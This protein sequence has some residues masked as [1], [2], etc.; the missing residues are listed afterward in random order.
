M[1]IVTSYPA[2]FITFVHSLLVM[3]TIIYV[4]VIALF[5]GLVT[6]DFAGVIFTPIVAGVIFLA[7][8]LVE[9]VVVKH[10]PLAFPAMDMA[11][12]KLAVAVYITFLVLDL[13]VF[14]VKKLV[15]KITG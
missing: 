3:P 13:V 2:Y 7:V 10:A 6:K 11:F 9:P 12:A 15:L 4:G 14:L 8:Q 5:F 1:D